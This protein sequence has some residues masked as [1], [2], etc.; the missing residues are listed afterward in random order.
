[1]NLVSSK[2]EKFLRIVECIVYCL[3]IVGLA[4]FS[5][6]IKPRIENSRN[7]LTWSVKFSKLGLGY[8]ICLSIFFL[9]AA[10]CTVQK[11]ITREY[12]NKSPLTIFLEI[13]QTIAVMSTSFVILIFWILKQEKAT[14]IINKLLDVDARLSCMEMPPSCRKILLFLSAHVVINVVSWTL[15]WVRIFFVHSSDELSAMIFMPIPSVLICWYITEYAMIVQLVTAEFKSLNKNLMHL[16]E[17]RNHFRTGRSLPNFHPEV[18]G[19][20]DCVELAAL[21]SLQTIRTKLVEISEDIG[22]FFSFPVLLCIA[23]SFSVIVGTVYSLIIPVVTPNG[24]FSLGDLSDTMN[25]FLLT[26]YPIILLLLNV[27]E[28]VNEVII[29]FPLSYLLTCQKISRKKFMCYRLS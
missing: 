10:V 18:P 3:K 20:P 28:I 29:I 24:A 23:Y 21:Q 1:M 19:S 13:A 9:S 6:C 27:T 17:I 26:I 22:H 4:P 7:I 16:K 25:W 14:S 8:N 12:I 2:S 15:V 11:I 5:I